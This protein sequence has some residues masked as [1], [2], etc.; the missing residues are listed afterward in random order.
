MPLFKLDIQK[1]YANETW[2]NRYLLNYGTLEAANTAAPQVLAAEQL[3]H[4]SFVLFTSYRVSDIVPNTD[5][6]ITTVVNQP[7]EVVEGSSVLPL[8]N[9]VRVDLSVGAGRPSRK[10]YRGIL[11][12]ANT[13]NGALSAA[14]ITLVS[15]AWFDIISGVD[16]VDPQL[17]PI[18]Q[19]IVFPNIQMRQLRRGSRRRTEPII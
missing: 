5:Q 1:S 13:E 18:V 12:E 2:T 6:F 10:Y 4:P 19:G 16:V 3:F 17:T 9:T 8:F 14:L 7:G 15:N 11:T